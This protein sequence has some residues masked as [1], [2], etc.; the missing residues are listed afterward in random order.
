MVSIVTIINFVRIT[1]SKINYVIGDAT[2]PQGNGNKIIVHIC[3]DIGAWGAGFVLALSKKW[4]YPETHYRALKEYIL[5]YV[6]F[7]NVEENI[8]VANMIAQHGVGINSVGIP[9]IRY[10]ALKSTLS[11]VNKTAKQLGA[12]VHM[13]RIGC[14]LAGGEWNIVENIVR[15]NVHVEVTVYDLVKPELNN[16]NYR[17]VNINYNVN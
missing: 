11:R 15:E 9:P 4:K 5:G 6:Y 16:P 7:I 8:Y 13:P 12:T 10:D 2:N 17:A 14:G 3:N 1:M